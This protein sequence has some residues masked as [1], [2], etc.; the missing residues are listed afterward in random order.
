VRARW[1]PPGL[2]KDVPAE[3]RARVYAAFDVHALYR[4]EMNQATI[5]ATITDATPQLIREL[6]TD[7]RT[8]H[9]TDAPRTNSATAAITSK[10]FTFTAGGRRAAPEPSVSGRAVLVVHRRPAEVVRRW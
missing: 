8:D 9:D 3:P 10:R 2:L 7:P 5:T 1:K 4:A 6:L